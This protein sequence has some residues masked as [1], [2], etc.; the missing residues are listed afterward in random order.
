MSII[1]TCCVEKY[2]SSSPPWKYLDKAIRLCFTPRAVFIRKEWEY[3]MD[4]NTRKNIQAYF[5]SFYFYGEVC[6]SLGE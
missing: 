2:L 3:P 1:V 6:P 5:Y 4:N